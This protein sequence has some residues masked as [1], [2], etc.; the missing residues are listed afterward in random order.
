ME[1][2]V[3]GLGLGAWGLR[4]GVWGFRGLRLLQGLAS[5]LRSG[6]DGCLWVWRGFGQKGLELL[7]RYPGCPNPKSETLNPK[8]HQVQGFGMFTAWRLP[9]LLAF[10]L[11]CGLKGLQGLGLG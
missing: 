10:R 1:F 8:P 3:W 9:G 7:G 2:R 4:V 6:V 5:G 11:A